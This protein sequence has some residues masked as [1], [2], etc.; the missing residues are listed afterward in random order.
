M[1][2]IHRQG[3]HAPRIF[4]LWMRSLLLKD[5]FG[6][7]QFQSLYKTDNKRKKRQMKMFR[8]IKSE[9]FDYSA[10]E[11]SVIQEQYKLHASCYH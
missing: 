4:G 1:F 8:L 11:N 2:A 7:F 3:C 9:N 5:L 10:V 6:P